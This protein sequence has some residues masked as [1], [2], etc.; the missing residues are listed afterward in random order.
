MPGGYV[1]EALENQ[2]LELASENGLSERD[3]SHPPSSGPPPQ[4]RMILTFF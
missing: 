4:V 3:L 2:G 1:Q